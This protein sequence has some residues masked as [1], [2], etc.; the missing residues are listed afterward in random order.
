MEHVR[1]WHRIGSRRRETGVDGNLRRE[2]V[3]VWNAWHDLL[4][5]CGTSWILGQPLPPIRHI[6]PRA[7][8]V[9]NLGTCYE[10]LPMALGTQI[11][12]LFVIDVNDFVSTSATITTNEVSHQ[13]C[14][15]K[16]GERAA[17]VVHHCRRR[18]HIPH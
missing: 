16:D 17:R 7:R 10:N 11:R 18:S 6:V 2:D 9:E 5:F 4:Q 1:D 12:C 8:F 3:G 14:L 13:G 15:L